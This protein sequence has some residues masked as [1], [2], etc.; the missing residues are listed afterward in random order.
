MNTLS[1]RDRVS[2][3][4]DEGK[5]VA[6]AVPE[7]ADEVAWVWDATSIEGRRTEAT[8]SSSRPQ[9]T[10]IAWA[11]SRGAVHKGER[12]LTRV[13]NGGGI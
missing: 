10:L 1:N 7:V 9:W 5:E 6:A 2:E 12:G 11:M 13:K 8:A 4:D 3:E